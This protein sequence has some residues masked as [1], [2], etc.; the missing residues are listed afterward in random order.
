M[1][2]SYWCYWIIW[3][4]TPFWNPVT[5]IVCLPY[6]WGL[7]I[8]LPRASLTAN[9]IYSQGDR[10][11]KWFESTSKI[12]SF[13]AENNSVLIVKTHTCSEDHTRSLKNNLC[14]HN[15]AIN[16]SNN[17]SCDPWISYR[18]RKEFHLWWV[19]CEGKKMYEKDSTE[20]TSW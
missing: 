8:T 5:A 9:C 4:P 6:K 14:P 15:S 19:L 18:P 11:F 2:F 10:K 16:L 17:L 3:S 13:P 7:S 20:L 12:A 1:N